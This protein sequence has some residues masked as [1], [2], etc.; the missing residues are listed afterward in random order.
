[1]KNHSNKYVV[2]SLPNHGAKLNFSFKYG[3]IRKFVLN[4]IPNCSNNTINLK[5]IPSPMWATSNLKKIP[6]IFNI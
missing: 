6:N 4:I 3:Q 1:M 5:N 2:L